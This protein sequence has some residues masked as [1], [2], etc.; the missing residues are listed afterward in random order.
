MFDAS[1]LIRDF[2]DQE[3]MLRQKEQD[4]MAAKRENNLKRLK[5]GLAENGKPAIAETINQ[6]GKAMQTMT[7][8]PEGDEESRYDIDL[9]VVFEEDD[10]KTAK[11]TRM[12][13]RDAIAKKATGMKNDPECK[14]KCVRVVY[15]DG[16]QCDFPV[17]RRIEEGGGYRYEV[18][19]GEGW[20]TSDPSQVN[21]W[22]N[23][24]VKEK[25]PE[26]SKDFQLRRIV[27]LMKYFSKVC[28]Y[29][30]KRKYPAGLLMT[31]LAVECYVP[32]ENRDDESFY[33]TVKAIANRLI[34]NKSVYVNGTD[35]TDSKDSDRLDRLRTSAE[36]S[37][38]DL[39]DV[40]AEN[41]D[42]T[43]EEVAKAWKKVFRHSYFDEE[44]AKSKV[45]LDAIF[46]QKST[47]SG[48]AALAGVTAIGVAAVMV[49]KAKAAET[50]S[51]QPES[52]V[53]KGG[54][55]TNA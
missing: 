36:K 54:G 1:Y 47:V 9:G 55:G 39:A 44:A 2:H 16:Y 35:I 21:R 27:R 5:S 17:F 10:A 19:V 13:V 41:D 29:K 50:Q 25:S 11:T 52:P 53:L 45:V 37:A 38:D 42:L 4:D 12:W 6:G 26:E 24:A 32:V 33:E 34:W 30:S 46:E 28:A 51:S 40:A 49:S 14:Q 22:F 7:H 31:A 18:S 23:E 48:L 20:T 3:V 8:P 15:S 43:E